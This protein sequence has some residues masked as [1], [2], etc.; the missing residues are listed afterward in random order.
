MLNIH[1][2]SIVKCIR[3]VHEKYNSLFKSPFPFLNLA[4]STHNHLSLLITRANKT[5]DNVLRLNS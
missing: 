1:F 3:I 4:S 2:N 5:S